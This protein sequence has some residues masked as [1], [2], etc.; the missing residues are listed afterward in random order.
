[1]RL[2]IDYSYHP[3]IDLSLAPKYHPL[4]IYLGCNLYGVKRK[5]NIVRKVFKDFKKN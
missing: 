2:Y 4:S 3:C 1:M 5:S